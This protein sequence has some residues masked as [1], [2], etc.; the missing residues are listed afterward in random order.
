[1]R[2][3]GSLMTLPFELLEII[4]E[5]LDQQFFEE[6][7]ARLTLCRRWYDLALPIISRQLTITAETVVSLFIAFA[8]KSTQ[9][10]SGHCRLDNLRRR[11]H[12]KELRLHLVFT[13]KLFN[14]LVHFSDGNA[15]RARDF[16]TEEPWRLTS[17]ASPWPKLQRAHIYVCRTEPQW[18]Q[19]IIGSLLSMI[20][21]FLTQ[22]NSAVSVRLDLWSAT[23]HDAPSASQHCE[24]ICGMIPYVESLV[25]HVHSGCESII[26]YP[27]RV[28]CQRL[29]PI[30]LKELQLFIGEECWNLSSDSNVH[31]GRNRGQRYLRSLQQ[32]RRAVCDAASALLSLM[33]EPRVVQVVYASHF[34]PGN[35]GPELFDAIAGKTISYDWCDEYWPLREPEPCCIEAREAVRETDKD[36]GAA[37]KTISQRDEG[38]VGKTP[39]SQDFSEGLARVLEMKPALGGV[40]MHQAAPE[41]GIARVCTTAVVPFEDDTISMTT[42]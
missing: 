19:G 33:I 30:K 22:Q 28:R 13:K 6:D 12:V 23:R 9:K 8:G 16:L 15:D 18:G 10:A 7:L 25:V 31:C 5:N 38:E 42:F 39:L 29:D 4:F 36:I 17:V 1:M 11:I 32:C 3:S 14:R 40:I 24:M 27:R 26:D 2:R 37:R 21:D 41:K 34:E 20:Q 35:S